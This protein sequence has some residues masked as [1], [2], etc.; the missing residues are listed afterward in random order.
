MTVSE[1][2]NNINNMGIVK[3]VKVFLATNETAGIVFTIINMIKDGKIDKNERM[4]L[5]TMALIQTLGRKWGYLSK[6]DANILAQAI[7]II[8]VKEKIVE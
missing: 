3:K 4:Y 1:I 5:E 6:E 7:E 8:L 2:L